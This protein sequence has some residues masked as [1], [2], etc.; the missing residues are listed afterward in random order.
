[1]KQL[2]SLPK[3]G[4]GL[5]AFCKEIAL[6]QRLCH[7]NILALLGVTIG[8]DGTLGVLTEYLEGGSLFARLHPN[9][10]RQGVPP[11]RVL[12][13]CMLADAARGMAYLHSCEPPIIHRDL[14]SHNLLVASD[15]S[16]R[17][18]DFGLSRECLHATAMTRVGSVQWAAPEVLLGQRYSHKCDQ[19]SFGVVC[20]EVLTARVPFDGLA[21]PEVATKVALEKM[22]LPVPPKTPMRLLRLIARCWCESP[23][24]RPCFDEL[25]VELQGIE[26]T[27]EEEEE[28][29]RAATMRP[30]APP[31]A[32]PSPAGPV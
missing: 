2:R 9:E 22:R 23:E 5:Q 10:L 8:T 6:M 18:A 29:L 11:P 15:L 20:W 13:M 24:A 19:W 31:T 17:V 3:E 28:A 1:M 32:P 14:K 7:P 21:Q 30:A 12:A 27:I 16:L 4:S 26:H 25:L